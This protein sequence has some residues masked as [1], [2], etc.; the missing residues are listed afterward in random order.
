MFPS[1]IRETSKKLNEINMKTLI[2]ILLIVFLTSG[3]WSCGIRKTNKTE[4][5]EEIKTETETSTKTEE[6]TTEERVIKKSEDSDKTETV[7]NLTPI[8][9]DKP[10]KKTVEEKDGKKITTWE[11]A[12]VNYNSKIDKSIKTEALQ[13]NTQTN[14]KS[15]TDF[16]A[17]GETK[18][19]DEIKQTG[20]DK[21]FALNLWWILLLLIPLGLWRLYNIKN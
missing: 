10:M 19:T 16:K 9:P 20:S 13:E 2:K 17:S 1:S 14:S 5:K 3:I 12:N 11:N 8:D 21:G 6:S 7:E 4:I 15:E 18:K